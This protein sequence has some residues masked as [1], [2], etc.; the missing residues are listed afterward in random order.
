VRA[1]DLARYVHL[2]RLGYLAGMLPSNE[3]WPRL[4]RLREPVLQEFDGWA[5]FAQSYLAGLQLWSGTR[6]GTF[7]D[8]CRRLLEHPRSPWTY[9][10]WLAFDG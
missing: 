9:F 3:C 6:G 5:D 8:S 1:W 10:G 2:L 7:E 4:G